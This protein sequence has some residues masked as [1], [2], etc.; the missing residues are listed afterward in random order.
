[1][2]AAP[3]MPRAAMRSHYCED[4]AHVET[5]GQASLSRER[6]SMMGLSS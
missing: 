1:M 3:R 5:G 2:L 6:L 4:S